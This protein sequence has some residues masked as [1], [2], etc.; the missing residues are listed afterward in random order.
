M[1]DFTV[2]MDQRGPY[3]EARVVITTNED[4]PPATHDGVTLHA[5][6]CVLLTGQT[7][8][9]ENGLREV[10]SSSW[11]MWRFWRQPDH[12]GKGHLIKVSEGATNGGS[13]WRLD[14]AGPYE[15]GVTE[16]DFS[17]VIAADGS[18]AGAPASHGS[19]HETGG[20]DV[21]SIQGLGGQ[22]GEGQYPLPD[23]FWSPGGNETLSG[24]T[25]GTLGTFKTWDFGAGVDE[26]VILV[27]ASTSN[28][29][30][31]PNYVVVLKW[32]AATATTGVVR[33][34]AEID[35]ASGARALGS[36]AWG[37]AKFANG[38][39]TVPAGNQKTASFTFT[40]AEAGSPSGCDIMRVRITRLGTDGQ[41]T[42]LGDA[43]V[44]GVCLY[45]S[46]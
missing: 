3:K 32:A 30:Y 1:S 11:L 7:N 45:E 13:L 16:L 33:W 34:K 14:T 41:D 24:A 37:T 15:I 43:Q 2:Y 5:G 20:P 42:M 36:D 25:G 35:T 6:D 40:N 9:E 44:V 10:G 8:K 17:E 23:T 31:R 29:G 27:G 28:S 38:T 12:L 22:A 4:T 39:A 46:D 21:I 26:Y 18:P 19:T